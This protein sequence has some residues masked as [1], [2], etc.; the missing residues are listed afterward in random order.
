[1]Q[2]NPIEA[3][4]P[5]PVIVQQ[6]VNSATLRSLNQKCNGTL[7]MKISA[8]YAANQVNQSLYAPYCRVR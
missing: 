8:S 4:Q 3:L 5:Q 2:M 7:N 1:M 6:K